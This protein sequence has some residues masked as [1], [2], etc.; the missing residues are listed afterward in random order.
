MARISTSGRVMA[1]LPLQNGMK[2]AASRIAVTR[3]LAKGI[4]LTQK[5]GL[6]LMQKPAVT[7]LS[8]P[9]RAKALS[10]P[11]VWVAERTLE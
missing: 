5:R 2:M 11:W 7:A 6:L 8:G 9:R 4:A 3:R 1:E 10:P